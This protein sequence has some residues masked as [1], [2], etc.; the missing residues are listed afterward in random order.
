M[1]L[2]MKE[3]AP[4][5]DAARAAQPEVIDLRRQ[6]HQEPELGLDLPAT[7]QKVLAA[8]EGLPLE[9]ELHERTSGVVA[10]LVGGRPG[11]T[12]LLRGDMDALPMPEDTD[13]P[14]RSR[15]DGAMHACGHDSQVAM[16][17]G[18]T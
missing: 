18:A 10:R 7:R 3:L 11:P 9:L 17:A 14:F 5:L 16:L 12:V 4:I 2:D 13:L 6:I 15:R 1:L 8:L